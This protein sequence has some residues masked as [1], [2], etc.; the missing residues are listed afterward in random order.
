MCVC[1]CV[2]VN[3]GGGLHFVTDS[4]DRSYPTH[5]FF[6]FIKYSLKQSSELFNPSMYG[7]KKFH[8]LRSEFHSI[9]TPVEWK[10]TTQRVK[11]RPVH[12][13]FTPKEV[14]TDVT[15]QGVT[16]VTNRVKIHSIFLGS[17]FNC[18]RKNLQYYLSFSDPGL[19][20]SH[21]PLLHNHALIMI[22]QILAL[23]AWI[24][25]ANA[26]VHYYAIQ[27]RLRNK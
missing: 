10:C 5:S 3:W 26:T 11:S 8:S 17:I 18:S 20:N 21:W 1:V 22:Y 4:S 25:L 15:T 16:S 14:I 13:I 6:I 27:L 2:C 23:C 9:L 7:V 24:C 12:S 19:W